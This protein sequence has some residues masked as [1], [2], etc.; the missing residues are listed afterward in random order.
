MVCKSRCWTWR[1]EPQ[2]HGEDE[3]QM[4]TLG[5]EL[6]KPGV[7]GSRCGTLGMELQKS[8]EDGSR[9]STLGMELQKPGVDGSRCGTLGMEL[10]KP[11]EDGSRWVLWAW[12]YGNLVRTG[13]DG[14]SGHGT[15]DTWC[16]RGA[17]VVRWAWNYGNLV[18][19]GSRCGTAIHGGWTGNKSRCY[20]LRPVNKTM[21]ADVARMPDCLRHGL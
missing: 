3:E 20:C 2:E 5:M 11:G 12:N 6:Q 8:G 10:Q 18:G 4:G 14:Y 1:M 16:G 7:D 15:T 21:L 13:A 19:T 17:D 9:C